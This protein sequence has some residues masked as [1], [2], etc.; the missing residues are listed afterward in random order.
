M[1]K[2]TKTFD[3]M[4]FATDSYLGFLTVSPANLGTGMSFTGTVVLE[5]KKR[6]ADEVETIEQ[7]LNERLATGKGMTVKLEGERSESDQIEGLTSSL[8]ITFSTGQTLAPNYNESIQLE[9]FLW[10]IQ[11]VGEF[12]QSTGDLS[13]TLEADEENKEK[14]KDI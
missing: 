3:K 6:R 7:L 5:G 10:A 13:K 4:G 2:L 14:D 9:D 1:D 11:T 12:E 8:R